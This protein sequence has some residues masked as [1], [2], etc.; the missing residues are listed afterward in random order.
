MSAARFFISGKVQGVW[1]RASTGERAREMDL[2]GYARN[3]TDGRVE[4]LAAGD[5]AA[6]D[7]LADWLHQGPPQAQVETVSREEAR[8][9]EAGATFVLD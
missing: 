4:V 7:A 1:F 2:R 8:E 9:K 6:I 5:A 3:L